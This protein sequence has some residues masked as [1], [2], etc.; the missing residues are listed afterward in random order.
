MF[1]K[2]LKI[3][4]EYMGIWTKH[5]N[6]LVTE[7]FKKN[8]KWT[9]ENWWNSLVSTQAQITATRW[10]YYTMARSAKM[11]KSGNVKR[12]STY[13]N[14]SFWTVLRNFQL[15]GKIT[16]RFLWTSICVY[17]V[18]QQQSHQ[19]LDKSLCACACQEIS[20]VTKIRVRHNVT[21]V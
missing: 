8:G 3:T 9:F 11:K 15:L 7:N 12:Q 13:K 10:F 1:F 4:K 21:V 16:W 18:K 17:S 2:C 6:S 19:H 20:K 14:G 5:P